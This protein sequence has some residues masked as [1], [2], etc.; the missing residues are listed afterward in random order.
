MLVPKS[1]LSWTTAETD[2]KSKSTQITKIQL[3]NRFAPRQDLASSDV[4]K[5]QSEVLKLDF[6]DLLNKVRSVH[7]WPSRGDERFSRLFRISIGEL[8]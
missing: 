3:K 5:Q 6:I 1:T 4:V 2:S 8:H 7:Q